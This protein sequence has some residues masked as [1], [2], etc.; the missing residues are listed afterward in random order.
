LI[1]ALRNEDGSVIY[2][3]EDL[4]IV[5][6]NFCRK[7]YQSKEETLEQIEMKAR[8]LESLPKKI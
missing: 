1:F 7:L 4:K 5:D 6:Y 8:V 2:R 3:K